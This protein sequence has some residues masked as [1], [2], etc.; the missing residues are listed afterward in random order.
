MSHSKLLLP[1]KEPQKHGNDTSTEAMLRK[2]NGL[3]NQDLLAAL[4]SPKAMP[5]SVKVSMEKS[6]GSDFSNVRLYESSLVEQAGAQAAASGNHVAFAPG[7]MDFHSRAGLELLGHELSH[8]VSQRR[9]EV[10]GSGL[11]HNSSLE[12]KAD[13]DGLRAMSAFDAD[14]GSDLTPINVGPA[15]VS[16][17]GPIQAKKKKS[18]G[19]RF[20]EGFND[21]DLAQQVTA[22]RNMAVIGS[23]SGYD[24]YDESEHNAYIDRMKT[25]TPEFMDELLRQ[26]IADAQGLVDAKQSRINDMGMTEDEATF[27][28]KYS[29]EAMLF[30]GYSSLAKDISM[31]AGNENAL[32]YYMEQSR[33]LLREQPELR[34]IVKAAQEG[35][36]SGNERWGDAPEN[37]DEAKF[38][39]NASEDMTKTFVKNWKRPQKRSIWQRLFHRK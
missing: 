33:Q 13:A 28:T 3:G 37:S 7:K 36:L 25:V 39:Q 14:L 10:S 29:H 27:K 15:P 34:Q 31:R 24:G 11:V 6:L 8:V 35:I 9:G 18:A 23:F 26:Q 38:I 2:R 17:A 21:L 20:I 12:H 22:A 32:L 30:Q 19:E 16:S 4:G 5:E 1:D